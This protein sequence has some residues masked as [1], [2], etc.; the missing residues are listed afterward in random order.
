M[1]NSP[2]RAK[3]P[4]KEPTN[5][6]SLATQLSSLLS[7]V[8]LNHGWLPPHLLL[9]YPPIVEVCALSW[10]WSSTAGAAG[11]GS[12]PSAWPEQPTRSAA[13]RSA[14]GGELEQRCAGRPCQARARRGRGQTT[15]RRGAPLQPRDGGPEIEFCVICIFFWF[16]TTFVLW[17]V[18]SCRL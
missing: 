1:V 4:G 7:S 12:L 9:Q 11:P 15:P 2:T 8:S 17:S 14:P 3:K 6:D 16:V 18:G 5:P 10:W 13:T